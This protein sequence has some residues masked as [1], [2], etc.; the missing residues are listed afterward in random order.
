MEVEPTSAAEAA[1]ATSPPYLHSLL[2]VGTLGPSQARDLQGKPLVH[3]PIASCC[4]DN[5]LNL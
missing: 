5:G 3:R 4:D 2:F 1:K